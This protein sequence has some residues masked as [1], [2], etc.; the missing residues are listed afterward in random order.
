MKYL[1]KGGFTQSYSYFTWRN[2]K[3]ELT[4]YFTELTQTQVR[5]YMRPNLFANTPDILPEFLQHSGPPGFH[6][7]LVLAATLGASYGIYG[8][9]FE[10]FEGMPVRPR[11]EEYLNS[12]KYEIRQWDWK[13]P[14]VF[15]EFVRL[16][17]RVRRENPALQ[18]D[19][20][21]RFYSTDNEQ[22]L[23]FGKT[24]SDYSNVILV[25][26]NLD[27]YHTQSGYVR[28]PLQEL[29]LSPNESYQ[30]QDLIT[31]AH[32]LWH[33]EANYVAL[34]PHVSPTHILRLRRRVR[35]ERDFDYFM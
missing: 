31:G 34:D 15:R 33:G 29:D 20:R 10:R 21:L 28:V 13:S 1:A 12:E 19:H 23:F 11:A 4:E 26:A 18:Y 16:V 2:S 27:P 32:F 7:R 35:T 8:P 6:L 22:L 30:V 25:I 14:T 17:N 24:T 9:V 5:E 3:Y